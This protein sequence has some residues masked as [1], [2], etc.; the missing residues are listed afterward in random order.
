MWI[1]SILSLVMGALVPFAPLANA[2]DAQAVS[3]N[4]DVRPILAEHCF[5]C[6]GRDDEARQGKLRLDTFE[7][8]TTELS[9]DT[10]AV[11]PGQ[12]EASELIERIRVA[13]PNKRMPPPEAADALTDEEIATLT[14]WIL[15][16]AKYEVHWAYQKPQRPA[17]PTVR[18]REWPRNAI[19][20]FVL[21]RM[22]A[23]G[24]TPS[25]P[26]DDYA[27]IRRLSLDLTGLLPS[28]FNA[29]QFAR[30][31]NPDRYDRAVD[32]LLAEPAY[33]EHMARYWLDLARY[34]DSNGYHIDTK[35]TM[36]LYRDWVV[37]AFNDNMPFDEFTTLQIAGDMIAD[38][39]QDSRIATGF[40]RNTMFNE[41]GG[42]DPE[43]FRTKAVVDRVN[44]TMNVWMGTTMSCAEC[45]D[46]KYDPFSQEEFYRLYAFFNN[47]PEAGGGVANTQD[48]MAPLVRF[49]LD[50]SA[51]AELDAARAELN[52]AK[53]RQAELTK[54]EHEKEFDALSK[55]IE[56]LTADATTIEDSALTAL[57]MEE[58][59]T[60]RTTRIHKRGN[61]LDLG[62]EVAAGVP[63]IFSDL[64]RS[65]SP[66]N[67]LDLARWLVHED[68]PLTARVTVN[69]VWAMLFGRGLVS[70]VDDFGVRGA[71]PSHPELLDFLSVEFMESG[72][73]IQALLRQITNSATYQQS[74]NVGS[75]SYANDPNNVFLSRGARFRM[76][77][78]RIRDGALLASGLLVEQLGGPPVFPYQPEGLWKEKMLTGFEVGSWPVMDGDE[79]YRRSLYTYRRRSVPYP[80]FQTFDAPSFEYCQAERPRTN[81][82]LQAL[83]TLNGPQFVEAARALA[84]NVLENETNT[85]SRLIRLFRQCLTREPTRRE[86]KLLR[87]VYKE[88]FARFQKNGEEAKAL[89]QNGRS[90]PSDTI[91]PEELAAWTV[92]T[93]VVL[94]LD[95]MI[96]KG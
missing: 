70:T 66:K 33:G 91:A 50:E 89:T 1:R 29:D 5:R 42:I 25:P 67:R 71:L 13:D 65:D 92:V 12:R 16:G 18:D 96:T 11:R 84:E 88:N 20:H 53:N 63:E 31:K 72:W 52:D 47:V 30:D 24:Y 95:E 37:N 64:N 9:G 34:A 62:D 87:S 93:S 17:L 51:Q 78:E 44:T 38:A 85:K 48:S 41:E 6:H 61:F 22:E 83:A 28:V 80:T 82:P 56:S 57:V 39:D 23:N 94:N 86:I 19:D 90:K 54:D 21:A 81:T 73:D 3:Y 69:R 74:S 46:H 75:K 60:P 45:H 40:H 43:E 58:M 8:A 55:M 2:A 15:E 68:N 14:H 7:G 77:A 4:R 35:R 49:P 36:W 59:K 27:L 32:S 10:V 26:A 79:L 76:D